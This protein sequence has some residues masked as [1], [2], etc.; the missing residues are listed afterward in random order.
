MKLLDIWYNLLQAF[1]T[2]LL[3]FY[4]IIPEFKVRKLSQGDRRSK[5]DRLIIFLKKRNVR[6]ISLIILVV[7]FGFVFDQKSKYDRIQNGKEIDRRDKV[8]DD[9][10]TRNG[11]IITT[12]LKEQ[13]L[14]IDT[15]QNRLVKI[16]DSLKTRSVSN[17]TIISET[18]PLLNFEFSVDTL[19]NP[20]AEVTAVMSAAGANVQG[21]RVGLSYAVI[22]TSGALM[23]AV[24]NFR[25]FDTNGSLGIGDQFPAIIR[26]NGIER[27]FIVLV[28][29]QY[30]DLTGKKYQFERFYTVGPG[31]FYIP[32]QIK[33]H[34]GVR[35]FFEKSVPF[36]I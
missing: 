31:K 32:L 9:R 34:V 23:L 13:G 22:D 16:K 25:R 12:A 27:K 18:K 15:L 19:N 1:S 24:R 30:E 35:N 8:R 20:T 26:V 3:A 29:G 14:K 36:R 28:K 11:L 17:K 4:A 6:I 21:V 10:A 5:R 33:W 2:F 7:F